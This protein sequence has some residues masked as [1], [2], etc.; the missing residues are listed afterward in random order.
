[1]IDR[2]RAV[3]LAVAAAVLAA[4]WQVPL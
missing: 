1:M 3:H 4:V 2:R